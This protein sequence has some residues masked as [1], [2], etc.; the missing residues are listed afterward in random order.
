MTSSFISSTS[1]P[2]DTSS[3]QEPMNLGAIVG[4]AIGG[5]TVICLTMLGI[6]LIRRKHGVKGHMISLPGR[7]NHGRNEFADDVTL[8]AHNSEDIKKNYH[9]G[10]SHGPVEMYSGH[11]VNTEP[12]E[13]SGQAQLTVTLK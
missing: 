6:V 10:S 3:K 4:G 12:V 11:H 13:L 9:W 2:V 8:H 5:L 1:G 7:N